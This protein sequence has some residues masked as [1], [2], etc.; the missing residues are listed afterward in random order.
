MEIHDHIVVGSGC[1]GAMAAQTLVEAG[2]QV[3]MLDVGIRDEKYSDRIP[4]ID[5]SKLR[6]TDDQ[7]DRYLLGDEF[8]SLNETAIATGAQLTPPRFHMAKMMLQAIR[9]ETFFPMESFAYGGLGSG[10]GLGCCMFSEAELKKCGLNISEMQ[11]A[12]RIIAQRIGVSGTKDDAAPYTCGD[13]NA[14]MPSLEMDENGKAINKKYSD[15]Q[16]KL[17][18]KGFFLGRPSLALHTED[19]GERKKYA[20]H[21]LDFYSDAGESAYRPWITINALKKKNNFRYLGDMA[22]LSFSEDAD[23]IIINVLD[24]SAKKKM[25]YR[26]KKLLLAPGVLQTGRI[27][28]RS[29]GGTDLPLLCNPYCYIP[30]IQWKM[31][32][33]RNAGINIGFA[34]N[35]LFHDEDGRNDDVAMA[36]IYS[37]HSLMMFRIIKQAPLNFRDARLLMQYLMPA[38]TIFGIHHP[39]EA[40]GNKKIIRKKDPISEADDIFESEY[41]LSGNEKQKIETREKKYLWAMRKL[42]CY[43]IKK[44]DPGLGSSIHY[45][46]ILPFNDAGKKFSIATSGLLNGTKNV[47]VADASGFRYLPAKGLTFSIFANAHNV[48]LN[49]LKNE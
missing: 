36:S 31:L 30:S 25:N 49:S 14:I 29:M 43:A 3:T 41:H 17:N 42:G 45:A 37:Y 21:D 23:G 28:L 9:S 1:A 2:V 8:E 22:V 11:N 46:G 33:K 18:F 48:A 47:F 39:E 32:G 10:W 16:E 7:Q 19:R 15:K 27:V 4:A 5:F 13:L 6:E 12:Y 40:G 44:I 35:S 20:N 34:Q 38:L 26:C 24:V